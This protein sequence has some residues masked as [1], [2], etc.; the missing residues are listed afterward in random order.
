M[1]NELY[2]K[3]D[4]RNQVLH[5]ADFQF[6]CNKKRKMSV[7][8][9]TL[10]KFNLLLACYDT[11]RRQFAHGYEYLKQSGLLN[12]EFQRRLA[13]ISL[14]VEVFGLSQEKLNL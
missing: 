3:K 2:V 12:L 6:V 9:P 1:N 11:F 5:S 10:E 13:S 14:Q 7:T 4:H 8:C